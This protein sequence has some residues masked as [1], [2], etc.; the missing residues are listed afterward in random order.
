M[1]RLLLSRRS[2]SD[3]FVGQAGG[4]AHRPYVLK[5][6]GLAGLERVCC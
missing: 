6:R 1:I 3:D 4:R 2:F 5:T